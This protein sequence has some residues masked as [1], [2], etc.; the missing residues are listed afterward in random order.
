MTRTGWN[1]MEGLR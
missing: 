1:E